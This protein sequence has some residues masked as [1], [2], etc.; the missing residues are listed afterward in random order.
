MNYW[1]LA[2]C[3]FLAAF[4]IFA[5]LYKKANLPTSCFYKEAI[6]VSLVS[7]TLD[8]LLFI[9][10]VKGFFQLLGGAFSIMLSC[11][12]IILWRFYRDPTRIFHGNKNIIVSPADGK[13]IY[14]RKVEKGTT[15]ISIKGKSNIYL[16]E[17][18]KT[19]IFNGDCWLIGINMSILDVH[20]NRAPVTGE[21]V[22]A[23]H[24]EGKFLSLKSA[25]SD[26]Q[27]ERNITVIKRNGDL[28]GIIQI[29][30]RG[31]RRI[32]S[33]ISEGYSVKRSDRIGKI[34][35]GSQV[36]MVLPAKAELLIKEQSQ[37]YAGITPIARI[38]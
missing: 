12:C 31:V 8:L 22:L 20:V 35:F 5:F 37:V 15:P 11:V 33:F 6:A 4:F 19:D 23:R 9:Y 2:V 17:L 13:V 38:G 26:V 28:I 29:A 10:P 27:N 18:A 1:V 7:S 24:W 30:S 21:V 34:V 14:I 25:D 3:N 32:K 36:D 16:G